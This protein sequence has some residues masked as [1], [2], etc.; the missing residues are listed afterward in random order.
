MENIKLFKREKYLKKIRGFY[1]SNEIIKVIT[2]VRRCGK[3]SLMKIIR[4]ELIEEKIDPSNLVYLNLDRK[5]YK[6]IKKPNQLESVIDDL[7]KD[8][9]G[10]IYLF[11]DE[12][13]NVD[14]FETLINAYREEG[15]FSIF[16]TGSNS[17]LLSGELVTKLTG[18][19]IEFEMQTLTFEEYIGMKKFFKKEINSNLDNE[20][21]SYITS[22][23]FPYAIQLDKI[24]DKR[25]YV[26]GVI[27]EIYEKDIRK[28]KKIRD[29]ELFNRVQTYIINNFGRQ[30]TVKALCKALGTDDKPLRRATLYSYLNILENAKII[31]KCSRFDLKSKKSING[32]EKYYLTD[33]SFYFAQS[34]DARINY[35]PMLENIFYI[36]SLSNDYKISI[37]RIGKLEIDFI[38]NNTINK[39]FMFAQI[40]YTIYGENLNE[41]GISETEE[42]EFKPLEKIEYPYDKIV[43]T[44]DHNFVN[45][46]NVKH[47]NIIDWIINNKF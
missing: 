6:G 36:Y 45:R 1:H 35:G 43:F 41:N 28:N 16:I 33:L 23:G 29:K 44:M 46:S 4:E 27:K 18:R 7:T 13:Q 21:N 15:N 30:S 31:K 24:E 17:Y 38:L 42:R 3:S 34:P 32:E 25:T 2:G 12:V 14:G 8:I 5:P 22:G 19:Y 47:L 9:K 39:K 11:I 40:A 20:F 26:N 37:G 10:N